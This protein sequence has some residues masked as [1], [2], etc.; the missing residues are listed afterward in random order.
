V[1][2]GAAAPLE[3]EEIRRHVELVLARSEF[4]PRRKSW[5]EELLR[6]LFDLAGDF[7]VAGPAVE[8]VLWIL[9]FG[10][11]CLV[12]WL[13]VRGVR[14]LRRVASPSVEL[15]G[16]AVEDVDERVQLLRRRSRAAREKGD[17]ALALRLAFF[18]LVV[19]LGR[20]GDLEYRD[21]WTYRELFERG[22]PSPEVRA[23]LAPLFVELERKSFGRE[24]TSAADV[25]QIEA[26]CDSWL[27]NGRFEGA[28]T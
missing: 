26:L 22:R 16:S 13:L 8:A 20:R 2:Q 28:T 9:A 6:E 5:L 18:A 23:R 19:G 14:S 21:A 15:E 24:P 12:A 27:A 11:A 7:G 10:L 17:L 3:A 4:Q 25:E 1:I